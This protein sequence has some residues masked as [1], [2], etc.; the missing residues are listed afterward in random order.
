MC[1]KK[2][3]KHFIFN[4]NVFMQ[5]NFFYLFDLYKYQKESRCEG[6]QY[7]YTVSVLIMK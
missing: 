6:F 7:N 3:K 5:R 2:K 4:A 1:E